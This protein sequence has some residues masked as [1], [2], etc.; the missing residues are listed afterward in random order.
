[1]TVA[2]A[3]LLVLLSGLAGDPISFERQPAAPTAPTVQRYVVERTWYGLAILG[4]SFGAMRRSLLLNVGLGLVG[5]GLLLMPGCA[6]GAAN[7]PSGV[8][9]PFF[10]IAGIG[11]LAGIPIMNA[12][13]AKKLVYNDDPRFSVAI[14][15]TQNGMTFG[16]VGSF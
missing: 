15:P 6:S 2:I 12:V 16:L 11:I 9:V 7:Q 4:L 13:M 14:V 3:S 5:G 8:C 1:M 10:H